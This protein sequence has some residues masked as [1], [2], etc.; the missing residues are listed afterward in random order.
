VCAEEI[1]AN[2]RLLENRRR[3]QQRLVLVDKEIGFADNPAMFYL[4]GYEFIYF[5]TNLRGRSLTRK[6]RHGY[7][8]HRRIFSFLSTVV[9]FDPN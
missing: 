8:P 3:F 7:L 6:P 2:P 9:M 1:K 5:A 4:I